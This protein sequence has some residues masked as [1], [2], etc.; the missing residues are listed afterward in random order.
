[1]LKVAPCTVVRSYGRTSKFFRLDGSLL[2]CI[3]MGLRSA[4]LAISNWGI[5]CNI[6]T[7][8]Y[9]ES[10]KIQGGTY[11]DS[12]WLTVLHTKSRAHEKTI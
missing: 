5:D 2:F 10:L 11:I 1:M 3:I 8:I 4:S 12:Y 9:V 6:H 7:S